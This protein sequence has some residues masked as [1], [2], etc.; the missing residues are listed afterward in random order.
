MKKNKLL[1]PLVLVAFVLL[2]TSHIVSALGA[3]VDI[4]P[5]IM[6]P[7]GGTIYIY[8]KPHTDLYAFILVAGPLEDDLSFDPD[9]LHI[10]YVPVATLAA[11]EEYNITYPDGSPEDFEW[12]TY[13]DGPGAGPNTE[14]IGRYLVMVLLSDGEIDTD[15]ILYGFEEAIIDGNFESIME[16]LMEQFDTV[17][18]FVLVTVFVIPEA[19]IGT[20]VGAASPLLAVICLTIYKRRRQ[21]VRRR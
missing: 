9:T 15:S 4:T 20:A 16:Y 18:Q 2:S 13:Y 1:L 21:D 14:Q 7:P 11:D 8:I 19:I 6:Q 10:E 5:E 17:V 3:D 12:I